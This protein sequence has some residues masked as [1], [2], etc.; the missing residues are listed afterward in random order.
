[1]TH[2]QNARPAAEAQLD[3]LL[4]HLAVRLAA[5]PGPAVLLGDLNLSPE[6]V[7]PRLAGGG[8]T[9]VEVPPTFPSGAPEERIDWVVLHGLECVGV[10]VPDVRSSDHRPV[11]VDARM[12]RIERFDA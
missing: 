10:E 6:L 12:R 4:D 8:W 3:A 9:A 11:V 7:A 2:L 5:E 1:M